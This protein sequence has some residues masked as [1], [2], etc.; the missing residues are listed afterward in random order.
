L[1]CDP[2]CDPW[3]VLHPLRTVAA[4][5]ALLAI[6]ALITGC[7]GGS[8]SIQAHV[9]GGATASYEA[10]P[11]LA[12]VFDLRGNEAGQCTGTVVAPS[13]IL[14]AGHCAENLAT[15][16]G[17]P[18][19]GYRVVTGDLESD[20]TQGQ[21]S[22]VA[23]VIVYPGFP[24]KS[25][26]DAALL[27]LETPTDAPPITLAE[28]ATK[29]TDTSATL[30]GW[31]TREHHLLP[32]RRLKAYTVV[33]SQERCEQLGPP[34]EGNSQICT[35]SESPRDTTG[36]CRGDSGGPL[37][38]D[39]SAGNPV[40][41]GVVSA[42]LGTQGKS[43][44][45]DLTSSTRVDALSSWTHHWIAMA[46]AAGGEPPTLARAINRADAVNLTAA[47]VPNTTEVELGGVAPAASA[48]RTFAKCDGGVN[49][50]LRIA[51]VYSPLFAR[52]HGLERTEFTSAVA[53][54]PT[55]A[56]A[57]R[58]RTAALSPRAA[59]CAATSDA[60]PPVVRERGD[61]FHN[62]RPTVSRLPS[63]FG[64]GQGVAGYR[65]ITNVIEDQS[66]NG[67]E[68]LVRSFHIY[69]DSFGFLHGDES[70]ALSADSQPQPPSATVEHRLLS[71]LYSR[72]ERLKR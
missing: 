8:P 44:C 31:E 64:E 26:D 57:A 56:M 68:R 6:V 61:V 43:G 4:I 13:L 38:A 49:P 72:A 3:F 48:E 39:S 1:W 53:T 58:D 20:P 47:D 10:F 25:P 46:D 11:S 34:K 60:R 28:T 42:R 54:T 51:L 29:L 22:R 16:V 63:P 17:N 21:T 33:Q 12:Y 27:V 36:A 40:E 5:L 71:L 67:K 59:R 45:S 30:V 52:V 35:E 14:T 65:S 9:F 23:E 70:I 66:R 32:S 50:S 15:G 55:A 7:G 37:I 19:S 41:I 24:K 69:L 2:T 18:P 62:G